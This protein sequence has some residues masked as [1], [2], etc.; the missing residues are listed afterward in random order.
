MPGDEGETVVNTVVWV[1]AALRADHLGCYGARRIRTPTIDALAASGVRFD[2]CISA[3]PRTSLSTT[4]IATGRYPH[5]HGVLDWG[6]DLA[7]GT[8]TVQGRFAREGYEVASFVFDEGFLFRDVPDAMVRGRSESIDPILGWLH[9]NAGRP[10]LLFVHSW[11][12][13]VP[14]NTPH[15]VRGEW[16]EGKRRHIERI[17]SDSASGIEHSREAYRR[18]VEYQSEHN[19][20]ALLQAL[21]E[22]GVRDSTAIVFTADYGE[23]WGERYD[24][25]S[26]VRGI[27]HLH[28]AGLWDEILHVPLIVAAPELEPAVVPWQV[29]TV[30]IAPTVLD[31]AGLAPP[32]PVDG[33]S[34]LPFAEG[35]EGADRTALA[36]TSDLGNLSQMAVRKPPWKL[37]R[38]VPSD[39]EEAY[40]LDVDPREQTDVRAQV[41]KALRVILDHELAGIRRDV[42]MSVEEE[43]AVARRLEDLG[44]L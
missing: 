38:W 17:Q 32:A 10:F 6:S 43:A 25:K 1:S 19:M 12:T 44:Y 16:R 24:D 37:V 22:L 15:R 36:V 14:Y 33:E 7:P 5:R 2:Q 30:D 4:S 23:S 31:I 29:R 3:A 9:A 40:R 26:E 34:L 27:Y 41:P 28:G 20:A 42:V 39:D 35:R 18:A 11:A 8:E 13:H 21:E